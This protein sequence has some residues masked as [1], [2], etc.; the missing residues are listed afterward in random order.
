MQEQY[1]ARTSRRV[2]YGALRQAAQRSGANGSSAG[3]EGGAGTSSGG[4]GGAGF[5]SSW[6]GGAGGGVWISPQGTLESTPVGE[7]GF[8]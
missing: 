8:E 3:S 6:G 2:D 4:E 5:G 1:S 7:D